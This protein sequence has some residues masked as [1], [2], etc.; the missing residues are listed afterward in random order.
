MYIGTQRPTQ[1][2][3]TTPEGKKASY[4]AGYFSTGLAR[5]LREEDR[6][7]KYTTDDRRSSNDTRRKKDKYTITQDFF[8]LARRAK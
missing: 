8:L 5:E 2:V 7:Q 3:A 6:V 4:S 1:G